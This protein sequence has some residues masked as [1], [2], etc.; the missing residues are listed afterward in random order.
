M[1]KVYVSSTYS[2]LEMIRAA[3]VE[4]LEPAFELLGIVQA[5]GGETKDDT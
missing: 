5:D 4:G 1:V 2:D 3:G